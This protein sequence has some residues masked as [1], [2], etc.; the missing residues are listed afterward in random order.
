LYQNSSPEQARINS[1]FSL[2]GA[3]TI[4]GGIGAVF[5]LVG[6]SIIL[7]GS[8]KGKKIEYLRKNGIPIKAKVQSVKTNDSFEVNGR[9]P[10]QIYA[11]WKNPATSEL[12]IFSSENIWFDPTDHIKNDEITVLIEKDNPNKYYV[13]ISFLPKVAS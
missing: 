10:Y 9:N 12:H 11:Q 8:I 2:W 13:D 1:F 3:S 5:F 7:F 6:F 4:L